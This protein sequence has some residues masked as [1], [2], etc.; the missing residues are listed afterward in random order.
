MGRRGAFLRLLRP[1]WSSLGRLLGRLGAL[2]GCLGALLGAS[3]AVLE[4]S[5]GPL[6]PSW[7]VG[8]PKKPEGKKHRKNNEIQR[9]WLLRALLGGL[10]EASWGVLTAPWAVWRPSWASWIALGP[11]RTMLSSLGGHLERSWSALGSLLGPGR[12][13]AGTLP[14]IARDLAGH[15]SAG[16]PQGRPR[17]RELE[18][19]LTSYR[20]S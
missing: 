6:G 5:S 17:A 15:F 4:R 9:F 1:S 2:L 7:S 16:D 8:K 20:R 19:L 11:S 10:L 12:D 18:I 14:G 3:L 13:L